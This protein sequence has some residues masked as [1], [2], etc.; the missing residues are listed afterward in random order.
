MEDSNMING[1]YSESEIIY[2]VSKFNN[3]SIDLINFCNSEDVNIYE[4]KKWLH[5]PCFVNDQV[6]GGVIRSCFTKESKT[7]NLQR[8]VEANNFICFKI[9]AV[10]QKAKLIKKPKFHVIKK[11]VK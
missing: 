1:K 4:F 6:A 5:R 10:N 8:S 9:A 3:G 11:A 2:F 7:S